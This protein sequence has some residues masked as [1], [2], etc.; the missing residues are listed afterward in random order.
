VL[1]TTDQQITSGS[2][3][4]G[5]AVVAN[6]N[7][8]LGTII[9][10]IFSTEVKLG[11]GPG[12][13]VNVEFD[14]LGSA[15]AGPTVIDLQKV[16]LDEV[17]ASPAPQVGNDSTDGLVSV[18][19]PVVGQVDVTLVDPPTV[20]ADTVRGEVAALPE[21]LEW[22]DEW[23]EFSLEIWVSNPLPGTVGIQSSDLWLHYNAA[24]FTATQVEFGPAFQT[25]THQ[26]DVDGGRVFVNASTALSQVG[27]DQPALLARVLLEPIAGQ[28][29][30]G[31]PHNS[32]DHH[33]L[34]VTD[35]NVSVQDAT[36]TLTNANSGDPELGEMPV[37]E[38]WPVMFD[39][40]DDGRVTFGDLA[41]LATAFWKD[42]GDPTGL[43][44]YRVDFDHN[45]FI[46][47]GDLSWLATN[48]DLWKHDEP[49]PLYPTE[50]P[51]DWR[52]D[53]LKLPAVRSAR[54]EPGDVVDADSGAPSAR[55]GLAE[56]QLDPIVDAAVSRLETADPAAAAELEDVAFEIVDLPAG[57]LGAAYGNTVQIDVDAAGQGWFVDATP[58]DDVEFAAR[59]ESSGLLDA[60]KDTAF[61]RVDLLTVVL[62]ELGH[63]LGYE[64]E[65][66]GFM[67][68]TL[69]PGTRRLPMEGA[70]DQA[71]ASFG[72]LAS[73]TSTSSRSCTFEE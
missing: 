71:F 50:F 60:T 43:V 28:D 26:I 65:H 66:G 8:V 35:L 56:A 21:N 39:P 46:D 30:P 68:E 10:T 54:Q 13:V 40:D 61:Q 51:A 53:T 69:L 47:F 4:P 6:V 25:G 67:E 24:Y 22:I 2:L 23:E 12:S 3:W 14:I 19:I 45:D 18:V 64:H 36:V 5:V 42:V 49:G 62:H 31:V 20:I 15:P 27:D 59:D 11:A 32:D 9:L 55:Y 33:A 34:P 41:F 44:T 63:V 38:V 58:W 52:P 7:D 57:V 48:F 29:N 72:E 16:E 73:V 37:P 1:D 17:P 70:V